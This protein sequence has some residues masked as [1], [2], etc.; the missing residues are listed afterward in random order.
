MEST[1]QERQDRR[2]ARAIALTRVLHALADEVE[3]EAQD[4]PMLLAPLMRL[5][6]IAQ[7]PIEL[8]VRGQP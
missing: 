6:K 7:R 8:A 1:L 4:N 2:M 5:R 3:R